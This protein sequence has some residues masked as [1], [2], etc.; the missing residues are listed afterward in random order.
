MYIDIA[1]CWFS[2]KRTKEGGLNARPVLKRRSL[3][4]APLGCGITYSVREQVEFVEEVVEGEVLIN[5]F[6]TPYD[7]GDGLWNVSAPVYEVCSCLPMEIGN[8]TKY[9]VAP[10]FRL[11][12][13]RSL[14]I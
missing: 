14:R 8:F 5:T 10:S 2:L 1:W 4:C 3:I 11:E 6:N 9:V 12:R 13:S 7:N